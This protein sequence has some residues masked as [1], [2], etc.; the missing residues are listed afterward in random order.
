M[1]SEEDLVAVHSKEKPV[2]PNDSRGV[3]RRGCGSVVLYGLG[4]NASLKRKEA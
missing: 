1:L 2:S 3:V 4:M